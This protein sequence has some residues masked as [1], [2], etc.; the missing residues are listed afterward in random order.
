M[1]QSNAI[2]RVVN[3]ATHEEQLRSI[4]SPLSQLIAIKLE[5]DNYLLWKFQIE[6]VILGYG[7]EDYIYGTN[8]AAP[9]LVEGNVNPE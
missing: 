6:N 8:Q 4:T 7:L 1:D 2:G 3:P 5:E 9:R